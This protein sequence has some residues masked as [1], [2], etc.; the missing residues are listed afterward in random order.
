[1]IL[2][3]YYFFLVVASYSSFISH[4]QPVDYCTQYLLWRI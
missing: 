3:L 1:M 4:S 2:Q